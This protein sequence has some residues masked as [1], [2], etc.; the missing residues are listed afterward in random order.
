VSAGS[1]ER[2]EVID[3]LTLRCRVAAPERMPSRL[4]QNEP[5]DMLPISTGGGGILSGGTDDALGAPLDSAGVR[6]LGV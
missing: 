6:L 3:S 4:P 2:S 5:L 1:I